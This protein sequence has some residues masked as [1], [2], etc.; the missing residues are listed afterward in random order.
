MTNLE[1]IE[2]LDNLIGMVEDNQDNDYDEALKMGIEALKKTC[3]KADDDAVNASIEDEPLWK[4]MVMAAK[5]LEKSIPE[6]VKRKA[7]AVICETVCREV[8]DGE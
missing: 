1:A 2:L 7:E 4:R 3:N 6:E 8:D 5:E